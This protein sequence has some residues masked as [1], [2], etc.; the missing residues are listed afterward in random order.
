MSRRERTPE[1]RRDRQPAPAAPRSTP[2]FNCVSWLG[3]QPHVSPCHA[4]L[5]LIVWGCRDERRE[6]RKEPRRS[7]SRD[8]KAPATEAQV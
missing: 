7:R 2:G 8:R 6:E 3:P 4:A 1:A 5:S